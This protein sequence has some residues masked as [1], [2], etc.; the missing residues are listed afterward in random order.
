MY[1][2]TTCLPSSSGRSEDSFVGRLWLALIV[3]GIDNSGLAPPTATE[4]ALVSSAIVCGFELDFTLHKG[5]NYYVT[6]NMCILV[7]VYY[8]RY[9]ML[10]IVLCKHIIN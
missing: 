10:N 8:N 2:L 1:L 3:E 9:L 4:E 5:K 6:A 7:H